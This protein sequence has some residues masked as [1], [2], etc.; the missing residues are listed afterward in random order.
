MTIVSCSSVQTLTHFYRYLESTFSFT[1]TLQKKSNYFS[2]E[3]S[4]MKKETNLY[5]CDVKI[6]G[7]TT[8]VITPHFCYQARIEDCGNS[9]SCTYVYKSIYYSINHHTLTPN[10]VIKVE[11]AIYWD[12]RLAMAAEKMT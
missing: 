6:I 12:A 10:Y 5:T 7:N 11:T 3:V 2:I 1:L 8:S 9:A 4:K